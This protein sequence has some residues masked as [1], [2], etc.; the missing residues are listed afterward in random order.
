MKPSP[1]T[2]E[3]QPSCC[4]I[5]RHEVVLGPSAPSGDATCPHCGH[6]LWFPG[7]RGGLDGVPVAKIEVSTRKEAIETL[8]GRLAELECIPADVVDQAIAGA[9][10]REELGSTGIGNGAAFPHAV[11]PGLSKSVFILGCTTEGIDF[12]SLD[13]KSVTRVFL[14]LT[15]STSSTDYLE[16]LGRIS[17]LLR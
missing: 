15:P 10:A 6:L 3:G 4:P 17:S 7:P 16:T 9:L 5:C 11:V 13:G 12:R 8:V 2:P 14:S 1:R